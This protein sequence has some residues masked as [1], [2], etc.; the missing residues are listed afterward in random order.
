MA[1]GGFCIRSSGL[2]F[3][4]QAQI[5]QPAAP[6]VCGKPP[7]ACPAESSTTR[8]LPPSGMNTP[9][10]SFCQGT[11]QYRPS[12]IRSLGK[13]QVSCMPV[14]GSMPYSR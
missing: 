4:A 13:N 6:D 11:G 14:L 5:G 9:S 8:P 1:S 2:I 3:A 7:K 10:M 12:P